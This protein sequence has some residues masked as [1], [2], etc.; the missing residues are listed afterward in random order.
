MWGY[1]KIVTLNLRHDVDRWEERLPL[2]VDVL[3]QEDAD[4]IAFQ[5]V[6]L[7][8]PQARQIAECLAEQNMHYVSFVAPKWG[9]T[10]REG[11]GIF[12]RVLPLEY[13]HLNLPHGERVA[14]RIRIEVDGHVMNI[15]NVHLH[16]QPRTDESIR[17]E[18]MRTL[19][20]WMRQRDFGNWLLVGDFNAL[21]DSETIQLAK[22]WLRSA[23]EALHGLEPVTHPTPLNPEREPGKKLSI[24]YILYDAT[25]F[26]PIEAYRCADKPHMDDATLYPSDHYGVA[27][28]FALSM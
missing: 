13:E 16:H 6:A 1:M 9:D 14:Q 8:S 23:H 26:H 19:L 20:A 2:V 24:D 4:I 11:I 12:T 22:T 7:T 10:P 27:A 28:R 5:E 25:V 17:Y 3:K 18:Q 15:A 21:P